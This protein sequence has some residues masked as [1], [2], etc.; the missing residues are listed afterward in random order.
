MYTYWKRLIS[1]TAVNWPPHRIWR[2]QSQLSTVVLK[3]STITH[4]AKYCL[5]IVIN[6][7]LQNRDRVFLS[8]SHTPTV[9]AGEKNWGGAVAQQTI[10]QTILHNKS[11]R[12]ADLDPA[13]LPSVF[14]PNVLN[15]FISWIRIW[16]NSTK[17]RLLWTISRSPLS[18]NWDVLTGREVILWW[19]KNIFHRRFSN[20]SHHTNIHLNNYYFV[21]VVQGGRRPSAL[22]WPAATAPQ[23][24][25]RST[26]LAELNVK[27]N[28]A[29][30]IL[31]LAKEECSLCV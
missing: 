1:I 31:T 26:Q 20:I 27:F 12:Q 29:Y 23:A 15:I 13:P 9:A 22:Y 16:L 19:W 28:T 25:R 24:A 21:C 6:K 8:I 11:N 30:T 18:W 14:L 17:T 5:I 2:N 4:S 3:I 10:S 7:I